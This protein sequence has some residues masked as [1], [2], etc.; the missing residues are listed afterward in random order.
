MYFISRL[1]ID[2]PRPS[3]QISEL[4]PSY[5]GLQSK[6]LLFEFLIHVDKWVT[7]LLSFFNFFFSSFSFCSKQHI[8]DLF[9]LNWFS[10]IFTFDNVLIS[11]FYN[12]PWLILI[13][14]VNKFPWLIYKVTLDKILETMKLWANKWALACLKSYLQTFCLQIIHI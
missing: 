9:L 4:I 6:Q 13:F 14:M 11:F 2:K 8:P 12:L 10:L 3:G 5:P 7:I 1:L